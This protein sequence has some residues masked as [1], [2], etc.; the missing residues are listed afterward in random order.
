[1]K[2]KI[3][4]VAMFLTASAIASV[5]CA[6]IP[7]AKAQYLFVVTQDSDA[8]AVIDCSI[9]EIITKIPSGRWPVRITMSP[10]RLRAYVSNRT[11]N[12]VS[13]IDT[14]ALTTTATI[15]VGASPQESAI[16]PDGGRLFLVHNKDRLRHRH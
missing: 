8:V 14:V 5:V 11:D 2:T 9:D 6:L 15:A 10:D 1:M 12:T 7:S 3:P 4:M 16:T 13:V